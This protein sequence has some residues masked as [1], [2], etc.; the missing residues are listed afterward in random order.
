MHL[1]AF[2]ENVITDPI[3]ECL[4]FLMYTEASIIRFNSSALVLDFTAYT[5]E[6][7]RLQ[8]F[9]S[10]GVRSG[11]LGGQAP[12]PCHRVHLF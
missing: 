1:V 8:R 2:R 6:F 10:E 3:R 11:D 12:G 4:S 5:G 9:W 7:I